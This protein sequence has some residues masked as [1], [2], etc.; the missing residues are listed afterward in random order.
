MSRGDARSG[1]PGARGAGAPDDDGRREPVRVAPWT[2]PALLAG[3]V[4]GF[5]G[6]M[7]IGPWMGIVVLA[8]L[9]GAAVLAAGR[10]VPGETAIAG[11]GGLLI[12][13]GG[14]MLIALL[15]LVA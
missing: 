5:L 2:V 4:V 9:V 12:G 10:R 6:G 8:G 3:L 1:G 7:L 14:V 15:H 11:A 13:F